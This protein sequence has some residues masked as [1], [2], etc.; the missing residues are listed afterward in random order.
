MIASCVSVS[1]P[2]FPIGEKL[3]AE[4]LNQQLTLRQL[5][6]KAQVSASLLSK[7]ENDKVNPSVRT[8]HS[9][10]E[11]LSLPL[12]AFFSDEVDDS[13]TDD[14]VI[15]ENR[16][17]TEVR[18]PTPIPSSAKE[19]DDS[20]KTPVIRKDA[21]EAIQLL[22]GVSWERLTEKQSHTQFLESVYEVGAES[23]QQMSHHTGL[24]FH[25]VLQGE[26]TLHLGP[27]EYV[28]TQGDAIIFDSQTPHRLT[29]KGH[30]T[31]R[32]VSV[33]FK[34]PNQSV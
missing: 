23:G 32:I 13:A 10:A 22:G 16:L 2:I 25:F 5:A 1:K 17:A 14:L 8:L 4:R 3:R 33:I 15:S 30:S 19:Q 12:S 21:R 9:L 28:L 20:G 29:N 27:A 7:L 26:L 24:E 31:L 18:V 11:A 34:A 6:A